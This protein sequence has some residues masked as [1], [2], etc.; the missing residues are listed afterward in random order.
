V[1]G[2]LT[3]QSEWS[4]VLKLSTMWSFSSLRAF[5]IAKLDP[6]VSPAD[7][8]KLARA[9]DIQEWIYPALRAICVRAESLS[10]QELRCMTYCDIAL[11][12]HIHKTCNFH[13]II[14]L[15]ATIEDWRQ[16]ALSGAVETDA[17]LLKAD[18]SYAEAQVPAGQPSAAETQPCGLS[19]G[20]P[21]S[22]ASSP[23]VPVSPGSTQPPPAWEPTPGPEPGI[24]VLKS[25]PS[26][27]RG[28]AERYGGAIAPSYLSAIAPAS[29][30]QLCAPSFPPLPT[31]PSP[32][33]I[34]PSTPSSSLAL[35]PELKSEGLPQMPLPAPEHAS[36][37]SPLRAPPAPK[38]GKSHLKKQKMGSRMQAM[39][40]ASP[41]PQPP[42]PV[43]GF[44]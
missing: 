28:N 22:G 35:A 26:V 11:V 19:D 21:P 6:I 44:C 12:S 37:D 8:L 39:R 32:L 20:I 43:E 5:A 34:E 10:L 13:D 33:E 18:L 14:E 23:T 3:E 16:A 15:D 31:T 1:V 24:I 29:I 40:A 2:D 36:E 9:H 27:P 30:P 41:P 25:T 4:A 42:L 7:R 17:A 38:Q